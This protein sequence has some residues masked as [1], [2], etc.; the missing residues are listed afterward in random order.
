MRR[1]AAISAAVMLSV[2]VESNMGTLTLI[3]LP[4]GPLGQLGLVIGRSSRSRI[5]WNQ[6]SG[7]WSATGSPISRTKNIRLIGSWS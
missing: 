7:S 6:P 2:S 4:R 5:G 3:A 1:R